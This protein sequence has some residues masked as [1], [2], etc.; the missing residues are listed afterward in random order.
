MSMTVQQQLQETQLG[1][2]KEIDR[3][4]KAQGLT[5]FL[6]FGTAI[7]AVRHNGFIPWD[8]DIDIFMT[9]NDLEKFEKCQSLFPKNIF[10]QTN[11]TDPEYGLM[12][13][14]VRNSDTT[15]IENEEYERDINHG[16]FV[17]IYPLYNAPTSKAKLKRMCRLFLICRLL[18]YGAPPR[19]HGL[20][21]K[22]I[23]SIILK[24][25]PHRVQ[26]IFI[27]KVEQLLCGQKETGYLT[28]ARY[29][30]GTVPV[31]PKEYFFPARWVNFEDMKA[32]IPA[33]NHEVLTMQYGDYMKLPPEDM[34]VVH[35]NYKVVDC[36]H[37][38]L[39]YKGKEY[40]IKD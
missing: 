4:C 13:T 40:C 32:P 21:M 14:R 31:F 30:R 36:N 26:K 17:D 19:N 35:H 7:G 6:T 2:L 12:I 22:M 28:R 34:R 8:D 23:S 20:A 18:L 11:K 5:Y 3:V 25:T 9:I 39:I 37:S 38:Y 24:I 33:K 29:D 16:V 1:I 27:K 10:I 15:L